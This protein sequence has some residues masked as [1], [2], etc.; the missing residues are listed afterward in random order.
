MHSRRPSYSQRGDPSS[1]LAL[2][3]CCPKFP[4]AQLQ[5]SGI[6]S[7]RDSRATRLQISEPVKPSHFSTIGGKVSC[8]SAGRSE[9]N[10]RRESSN[11]QDA[12]GVIQTVSTSSCS[13]L[14]ARGTLLSSSEPD[15]AVPAVDP[16]CNFSLRRTPW[17][18][19][20][21]WSC[22]IVFSASSQPLVDDPLRREQAT[23]SATAKRARISACWTCSSW[24]A[25]ANSC[26]LDTAAEAERETAP[27][28]G[29]PSTDLPS[30]VRSAA[31]VEPA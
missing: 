14:G 12:R 25:R 22:G 26:T 2:G 9:F 7:V 4:Q 30:S 27:G 31:V 19:V 8:N 20:V 21:V 18:L 6:N 10:S 29:T 15:V 5:S 17:G 24:Y 13:M 23:A 16:G 28:D 11:P 3:G 1:R